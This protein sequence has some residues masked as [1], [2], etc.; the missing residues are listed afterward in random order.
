M[1]RGEFS[2][3][4]KPV[5]EPDVKVILHLILSGVLICIAKA[6]VEPPAND[7]QHG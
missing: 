1:S 3:E 7:I 2:K 4:L 5:D 6:G